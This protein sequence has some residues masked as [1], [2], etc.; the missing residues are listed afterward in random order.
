METYNRPSERP[1][2][3]GHW[4]L[5]ILS[6]KISLYFHVLLIC[7]FPP[8]LLARVYMERVVV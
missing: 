5:S 6:N 8:P 3:L 4:G 7:Q 1:L 2:I